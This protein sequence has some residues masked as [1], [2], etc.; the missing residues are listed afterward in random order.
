MEGGT[1]SAT[2]ADGTQ[3]RLDIPGDALLVETKIRLIPAAVTGLPFGGEQTYAAQ[4]QP[5]GLTFNNFATLSILPAQE[6]PLKE[7]LFFGYQAE[8]K[9]VIFAPPVKD[10]KELKIQLL[11]FSGYGVTKG[12]LADPEIDARAAGWQRRAPFSKP[13]R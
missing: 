6:I 4:L 10:S 9:D 2:G 5:E 12:L 7:Q 3:Y 8:G 1:L 11:H 13:G